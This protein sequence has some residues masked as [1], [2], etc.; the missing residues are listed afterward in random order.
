MCCC[1]LLMLCCRWV[2]RAFSRMGFTSKKIKYRNANKFSLRNAIYTVTS[3]IL[4]R[5]KKPRLCLIILPPQFLS[6]QSR[7][8][9]VSL[10][11]HRGWA[12]R[13]REIHQVRPATE[14]PSYSVTLLT[15]LRAPQGF[16]LSNPI[17]GALVVDFNLDC[18]PA[19]LRRHQQGH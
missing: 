18:S 1:C 5:S 8:D 6:V 15:D 9:S 16:W 17:S 12:E 10:H 19:H 11:R 2:L 7:F 13:G 14:F 3:Q 4:G